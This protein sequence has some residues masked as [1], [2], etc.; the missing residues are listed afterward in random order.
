MAIFLPVLTVAGCGGNQFS[1]KARSTM[2]CSID[3]MPTGLLLMFKVQAASQGAGHTRPVNSGKLLVLC[4][5]WL[6]LAQS[7]RNTRSLKSGMRSEEHTSEL[8][9]RPHLV[10]R[11]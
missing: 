4:S 10:C 1:S 8:Q 2:D 6:A 5:T 11:L 3:L 9:S 7:L